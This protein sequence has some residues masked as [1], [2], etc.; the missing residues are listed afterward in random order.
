MHSSPFK[1]PSNLTASAISAPPSST[2]TRHFLPSSRGNSQTSLLTSWFKNQLL[3]PL[4]HLVLSQPWVSD[5]I[6]PSP[7]NIYPT[8]YLQ[9]LSMFAALPHTSPLPGNLSSSFQLDMS[10]YSLITHSTSCAFLVILTF[11]FLLQLSLYFLI[12]FIL[13]LLFTSWLCW[14]QCLALINIC[15]TLN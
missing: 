6:L 15:L 14:E 2:F 11:A 8:S 3:V 12:S 7:W 5:H 10:Y 13:G 1:E 9:I 4:T